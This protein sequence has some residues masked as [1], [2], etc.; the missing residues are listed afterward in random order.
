MSKVKFSTGAGTAS[1]TFEQL[2]SQ[3]KL[4]FYSTKKFSGRLNYLTILTCTRPLL[5]SETSTDILTLLTPFAIVL[6]TSS[7]Q[8]QSGLGGHILNLLYNT[9]ILG[10]YQALTR[11]YSKVL[12][13]EFHLA[14]LFEVSNL[15]SSTEKIKLVQMDDQSQISMVQASSKS[16]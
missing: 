5:L 15:M 2:N 3:Y 6:V 13:I 8:F 1:C 14:L 7:P 9:S 11:G 12:R 4:V 10:Y 16:L